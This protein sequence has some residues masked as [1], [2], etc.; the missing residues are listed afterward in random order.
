MSKITY[1]T[2]FAVTLLLLPS[3]RSAPEPAPS[4]CGQGIR[5]LAGVSPT[6]RADNSFRSG[7]PKFLGFRGFVVEFPGVDDTATVRRVGYLIIEGTSDYAATREC[8][9]ANLAARRYAERYNRRL[10][11][12]M[13]LSAPDRD[14]S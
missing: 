10:A 4:A 11:E 2:L 9:A 3:C 1:T 5:S 13:R 12:L 14:P 6:E 7:A 8:H